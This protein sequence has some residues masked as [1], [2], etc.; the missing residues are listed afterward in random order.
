MGETTVAR[1]QRLAGE[2]VSSVNKGS[3]IPMPK[4]VEVSCAIGQGWREIK[5]LEARIAELEARAVPEDWKPTEYRN[6]FIKVAVSGTSRG[7]GWC[8]LERGDRRGCY[9]SQWFHLD[10]DGEP[11][12]TPQKAIAVAEASE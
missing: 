1:L 6:G 7:R 5:R 8:V 12:D 4:L 11:F 2:I 9:A 3:I 10:A